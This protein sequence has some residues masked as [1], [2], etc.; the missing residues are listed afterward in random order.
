MRFDFHCSRVIQGIVLFGL[1]I[2]APA[3]LAQQEPFR[4]VF[5][6]ECVTKHPACDD[7]RKALGNSTGAPVSLSGAVGS[8]ALGE[9]LTASLSAQSTFG[10]LRANSSG[11]FNIS[12]SPGLAQ[13]T[14][15]ADF[16]DIITTDFPALRGQQGQ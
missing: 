3:C 14:A 13:A 12:V 10:V 6:L 1:P 4:N 2:F 8:S 9:V 16:G 11:S 7:D 15:V 5:V